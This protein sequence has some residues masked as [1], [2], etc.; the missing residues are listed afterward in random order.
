M[1]RFQ[2]VVD[3]LD[4]FEVKWLCA[5]MSV[6]RSSFYAWLA[7]ADGR[8]ARAAADA[9]LAERIQVVHD[10]DN[11]YGAPR[12]TAELNDGAPQGERVN[13]KRVAR[14]MR[15]NG[16]A[17]Y[18]RRRRFTTTVADPA[19]QKVPD[20]LKRDFTA[21]Q[22]NTRYVG[23][24]TYLP[25]ATGGN[26]YLA[27]VIDCCSRRVA[28]WAI[29]EHMRTEL[30]KDALNA[31]AALRGGLAG[32]VF[33]AD[34]GSQYTSRDFANLCRDL[35]VIQSMGGVGSSADNALA[36]SFNA[37]LKREV[38]QDRA[39]WPDAA[40]CRREVFRWLAR[41]NTQRRHSHCRHSSP[42]TYEKTL[43]TATLPEAA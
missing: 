13:H 12:I 3:H 23:D 1:S 35:E 41:Y 19:N 20:L 14:V 2:F 15:T 37:A 22:I 36:E 32:A 28:G 39:C 27:T 17:G 30:V 38:L 16:I 34:H 25:L 42:A 4:T 33:H 18:R 9:V 26:L 6:A 7:G 5:V 10:A 40:T 31:A 43:T 11:T 29:A 8:A 24:I 21:E